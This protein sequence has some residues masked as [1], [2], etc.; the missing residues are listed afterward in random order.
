MKLYYGADNLITKPTFGL[1]NPSNDYG[2][3]FYLTPSYEMAKLWASKNNPKGYAITYDVDM[4]G[5]KI[6]YLNNNTNE[7]VL[8]WITILVSHRFSRED[9]NKHRTAIKWLEENYYPSI[10]KYDMI[11]GYR[12]D[13]SY[14]KY[15]ED[16]I[17]NDLSIDLL[18]EAM[19]LGKLGL[20]YV[21]MSQKAFNQIT[22]IKHE[23]IP[24]TNEY[25]EFRYETLRQ[26]KELKAKDS[27][28]NTFIRDIMRGKS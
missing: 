1:G 24:F 13:D 8:N 16:F 4:S 9:Y 10:D 2:L 7:D 14:F 25:E 28:N 15:S 22:Y 26:Y 19:I 23:E 20:Q 21:L 5:L 17:D 27:I 12:A 11:V 18:K 3:G 6:L